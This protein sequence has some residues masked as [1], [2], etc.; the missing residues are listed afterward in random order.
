MGRFLYGVEVTDPFAFGLAP[1]ALALVCF[2]ASWMP[3]TRA[4]R[5]EP[6]VAL[7]HE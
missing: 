7:R 1:A 2:V 6:A 3:A 4:T 5:I